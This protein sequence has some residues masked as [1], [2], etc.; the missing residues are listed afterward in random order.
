VSTS[1]PPYQPSGPPPA[2]RNGFGITAVILGPIGLLFGLIPLTGF[3][4][5]ICGVI[6]LVLGL[7]GF[8]RV[9]KGVASN[10]KTSIAGVVLSLLALILGIWGVVIVGQAFTKLGNDLHASPNPA[11]G[12]GLSA[13]AP[14]ASSGAPAPAPASPPPA[15]QTLTGKGSDVVDLA[16]PLQAGVV[17]FDCSK[18]TGNVIVKTDTGE[19]LVN[20]VGHYTGVRLITQETKRF[21]VTAKGSWTL[22]AGGFDLAKTADG[23]SPS[24]GHGDQVLFFPSSPDKARLT[25]KGKENFIVQVVDGSS[26]YPDLLVNDIGSWDGTVPFPNVG[27]AAVLQIT[28]DGDWT[29]APS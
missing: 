20:K 7:V 27:S 25:H 23:K 4:A 2:P 29:V 6:G 11:V 10:R 17:T 22:T 15:P 5:I 16:T 19:L 28:A 1:P 26:G 18:C 3:V 12:A 13:A 14:P 21:Q 8:S 9:R 24:T